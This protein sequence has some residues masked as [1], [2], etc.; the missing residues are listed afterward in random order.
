[1]NAKFIN[2]EKKFQSSPEGRKI[3]RANNNGSEAA[4]RPS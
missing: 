4:K 2:N 1:M 3:A